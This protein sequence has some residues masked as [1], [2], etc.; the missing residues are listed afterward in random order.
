MGTKILSLTLS[1]LAILSCYNTS[2]APLPIT[3]SDQCQAAHARLV[4]L[5]CA[6]A[7]GSEANKWDAF[8]RLAI[9]SDGVIQLDTSCIANAADADELKKRC[10]VACLPSR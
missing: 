1:L 4:Q 10:H 6:E 9:A 5:Q 8:C 7:N 3:Y 2:K